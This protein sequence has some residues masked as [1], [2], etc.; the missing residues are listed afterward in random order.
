ML[1]AADGWDL[2]WVWE[3]AWN[4][5]AGKLGPLTSSVLEWLYLLQWWWWGL[6]VLAVCIF[7]SVMSPWQWPKLVFGWIATIDITAIVVATLV[8]LRMRNHDG[9]KPKP[10]AKPVD[11]QPPW[12]WPWE[13]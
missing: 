2:T 13:Q 7:V 6:V 11:E 10:K 12:K 4:F 8:F 9:S 1:N 3:S 5:L